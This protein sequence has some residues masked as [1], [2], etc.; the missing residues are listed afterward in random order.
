[1]Q[2]EGW[3]YYNYAAIPTTLPHEPINE[4]PLRDGGIWKV[5]GKAGK[6]PMFVQWVE[7][8]DCA[9]ETNWWYVIKDTPF[10]IN[11]LKAKR[12]YEINKGIKNFEVRVIDP[13]EY[14]EQ[15]YRVTEAAFAS[16]PA[17]YRPALVHDRHIA[18]IHGWAKEG[19]FL[20]AAFDRETGDLSGYARLEQK[21]RYMEF[22]ILRVVPGC[23]AKGVNA[24][25]VNGFLEDQQAFL[26]NGGYISDGTRNVRHETSFQD[27]LEKYFGF[28]KA[29][30]KLHMRYKWWLNF[31]VMILYPFRKQLAKISGPSMIHLVNSLLKMEGYTAKRQK[32][33]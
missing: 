12:R 10:D 1:M 3:R 23:E 20:Y 18:E 22:A 9:C 4:A 27:Y 15:V 33:V 21:G 31:A 30:C 25:I 19:V 8:F 5:T 17:K 2:I 28:R 7:D 11:A 24:A 29:Y 6:P 32:K 26:E 13:V 16:Y 14:D